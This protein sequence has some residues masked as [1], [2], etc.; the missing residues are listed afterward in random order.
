MSHYQHPLRRNLAPQKQVCTHKGALSL[1]LHL[2]MC[3]FAHG[4]SLHPS[5]CKPAPIS[6][7]ASFMVRI[8]TIQG[9]EVFLEL[10]A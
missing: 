4:I 2:L 8:Y 1:N 9:A 3:Q 10:Q 5:E 7:V 6:F